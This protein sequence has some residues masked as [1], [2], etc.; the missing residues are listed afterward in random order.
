[1]KV[2]TSNLAFA[3]TEYVL[4]ALLRFLASARDSTVVVF[5][6]DPQTCDN[7]QGELVQFSSCVRREVDNIGLP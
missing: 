6:I 3:T 2:P 4:I 1:M 5:C 7:G